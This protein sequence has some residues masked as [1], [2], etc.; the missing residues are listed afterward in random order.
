CVMLALYVVVVERGL[1]LV[2]QRRSRA[3]ELRAAL[4]LVCADEDD[5]QSGSSVREERRGRQLAGKRDRLTERP[6]GK[7]RITNRMGAPAAD[8]QRDRDSAVA[9]E[10]AEPL[11]RVHCIVE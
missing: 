10:P 4:L 1:E 3:E 7:R 5:A 6:A 11:D 8:H 2:S 9:P